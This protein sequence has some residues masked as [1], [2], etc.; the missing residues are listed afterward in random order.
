MV[1]RNVCELVGCTPHNFGDMTL[2]EIA[3]LCID[4][5][6]DSKSRNASP[7]ELADYFEWW[8]ALTPEQQL[9]AE[10]GE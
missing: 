6:R 7:A 9:W 5:E 1:C 10:Y 2:V 8:N 3:T 4:P